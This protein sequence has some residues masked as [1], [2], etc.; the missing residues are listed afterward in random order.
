MYIS[1]MISII[2]HATKKNKALEMMHG[3]TLG[4]LPNNSLYFCTHQ[5]NITIFI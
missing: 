2:Q 1:G 5:P 4:K 3:H